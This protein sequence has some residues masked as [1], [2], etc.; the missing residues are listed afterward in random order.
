MHWTAGGITAVVIAATAIATLI[1]W[2]LRW[3]WRIL[4]RT[5]RFLDDYF[6]EPAREGLPARPGV[7]ARLQKVEDITTEVRTEIRTNGGTTL[8]DVVYQTAADMAGVKEALDALT[9]RVELFEVQRENR[10]SN[11]VPP[12]RRKPASGR[13]S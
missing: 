9:G 7:M 4:S 12:H 13:P 1:A 6:G 10:E 11:G 5:T 2:A 3:A 8:R